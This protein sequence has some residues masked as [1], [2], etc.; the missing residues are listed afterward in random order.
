VVTKANVS[1]GEILVKVQNGYELDELHDVFVGGVSTA[2]PLVYSST[3]SGWVAQA[4]TSVGVANDAIVTTKILDGAVT[5]AK[6]ASG[7]I[8]STHIAT[9]AVVSGDIA[10]GVVGSAELA[11]N[12]VVTAKINAAAV[13]TAKIDSTGGSNGW[14]LT[15]D[16]SGGATFAASAAPSSLISFT[17][18]TTASTLALTDQDKIVQADSTAAFTIT[19]P[20]NSSVAFSTGSQVNLLQIGTGQLTVAGGTGVTVNS[21]LGLKLRARWSSATLIKRDTNTWVLVGDCDA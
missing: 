4:L 1:T 16:G 20:P 19:V 8:N 15:A 13:N 17:T 9:G 18:Y 11:D 12:A 5:S 6:I 7:S 3:S 10:A 21:A 2:L 14:I